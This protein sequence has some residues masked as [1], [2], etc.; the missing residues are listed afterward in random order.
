MTSLVAGAAQAGSTT[1]SNGS[2]SRT[3]RSGGRPTAKR[4]RTT[5]QPPEL[6]LGR[7][8]EAHRASSDPRSIQPAPRASRLSQVHVPFLWLIPLLIGSGPLQTAGD[9]QGR[10]DARNQLNTQT[11]RAELQLL[12]DLRRRLCPRE[13]SMG[14]KWI[15]VHRATVPPP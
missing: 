5:A 14:A 7:V 8:M 13:E 15:D 2:L 3:G 12:V 1:V 11:Y 9:C 4:G 6:P 10:K